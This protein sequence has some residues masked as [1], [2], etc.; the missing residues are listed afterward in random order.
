MISVPGTAGARACRFFLALAL[1]TVAVAGKLGAQTAR[2]DRLTPTDAAFAQLSADVED[3]R[4][5]LA[6]PDGFADAANALTVYSYLVR[7]GDTLLAVAAR[8][9]I[10]YETLATINRISSGADLAAGRIALIP[11]IPGIYLPMEPETDIERLSTAARENR[12]PTAIITLRVEGRIDRFHFFAGEEFSPTERAF[13][14]NIAFRL[15]LAAGRLTSGFGLRQN[16]LTGTLKI[17][18]GID[19]AAPEGTE[20]LAARDGTVVEVGN[21][22]VYGRFIKIEHDGGWK[23]LYGHLS[24]ILIDLRKNVRSGTI[25]GRVGTTG[26]TTGPHLHFELRREGTAKDPAPLL[27]RGFER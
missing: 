25:I 16:P 9:G 12:Q 5:R 13:F 8:C 21:D 26:Q 2:I 24:E 27:P 18:E 14:L 11:S 6:R 20:V 4:R 23:S 3:A 7:D 22:P 19:L 10:P 17:H 15:P 1:I